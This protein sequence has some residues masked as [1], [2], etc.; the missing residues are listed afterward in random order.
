MLVRQ[1]LAN[2]SKQLPVRMMCLRFFDVDA[3]PFYRR[4]LLCRYCTTALPGTIQL[5]N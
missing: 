5:T 3:V 2:R 4:D 1:L